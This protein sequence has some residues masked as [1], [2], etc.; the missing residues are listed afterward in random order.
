[1][2]GMQNAK[3]ETFE[4]GNQVLS[5]AFWFDVRS[6]VWDCDVDDHG[7]PIGTAT[8]ETKSSLHLCWLEAGAGEPPRLS[9][10]CLGILDEKFALPDVEE[11]GIEIT[12]FMPLLPPPANSE[13]WQA[14]EHTAD[15]YP[16]EPCWARL[17]PD[18][19]ALLVEFVE[20]G[21]L[22]AIVPALFA[23]SDIDARLVYDIH[24]LQTPSL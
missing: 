10:L 24:P 8:D 16:D 23:S 17:S 15:S 7:H 3:W 6:I 12:R 4:V 19:E 14:C 5:G 21:D 11:V 20:L 13:G 18:G 9:P 2:E 22:W 1:M